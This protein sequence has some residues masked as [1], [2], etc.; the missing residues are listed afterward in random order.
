ML[1]AAALARALCAAVALAIGLLGTLFAYGYDGRPHGYG[2]A[3]LAPAVVHKP[4]TGWSGGNPLVALGQKLFFDARLSG[5]GTTA[6]ASCHNPGYGF[7]EPRRVSKSDNGQLG[8]RNAP[9][10]LDVGFF[11]PLM[12]DGRFGSLEQ[13][14]FGPFESGEMGIGVGQA[15]QRVN[16]DPQYVQLFQAAL[17]GFATP[18]GMARALAAFQRTLFSRESRVDR[19]L[20]REAG[21]LTPQERHGYELFT[22]RAGCSNCHEPFPLQVS[23]SRNGRAV[24][25]DFQ[26]HNIG[27]GYNSGG[28]PDA[29]RYEQSKND[30]DWGTYRTPSL[31]NSARTPPYM[32]DGSLATLEEVVQFYSAGGRPNPNLSPLIRPLPLDGRD[33]AALVAFLR[34]MAD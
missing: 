2:P 28:A 32:H 31:R 11:A 17:G 6:C 27:I 34:A 33:K 7:A 5:T 30:A 15:A 3:H 26:F 8:R 14:A 13:Q 4:A 12:W 19:F 20:N 10:L 21:A 29:G 24:F 16:S 22:G 23:V 18:D 9:A 25:T 1:P